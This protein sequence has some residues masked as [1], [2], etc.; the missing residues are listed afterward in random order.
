MKDCI[1]YI[2]EASLF[3]SIFFLIYILFLRSATF[4]RFN[5]IYLLAG[6]IVP[7]FLSM[8]EFTYDV[9]VFYSAFN[10]PVSHDTVIT[11]VSANRTDYVWIVLSLLYLSGVVALTVHNILECRKIHKLIKTGKQTRNNNYIVV[12]NEKIISSHLNGFCDL[13]FV[14]EKLAYDYVKNIIANENKLNLVAD[15]AFYMLPD[16]SYTLNRQKNDI[17]IGINVSPLAFSKDVFPLLDE[18]FSIDD[19]IKLICIPHVMSSQ[20]GPQDDY[21]FLQEYIRFSHFKDKIQLLP[22]DLGARKTKGCIAQCDMVIA[23]RMHACVAGV[24]VATPTLFLTYSNKGKGMAQYVYHH[25][26]WTISNKE[27]NAQNLIGRVNEMLK[28]KEVI[29]QYLVE[30]NSRFKSDA[31]QAILKL[32]DAYL[33]R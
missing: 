17:L 6:L 21:S 15:P 13:I 18:L 7:F 33:G 19:N 14:R 24:S 32:K 3:L 8:I 5:R 26:D 16:M 9:P 25:E 2:A 11:D 10:V 1:I 23:S 22:S 4:L 28:E 27:L 12:E 30:N 31:S 20:G 29:H